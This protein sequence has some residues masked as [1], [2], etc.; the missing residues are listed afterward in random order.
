MKKE[1]MDL[2]DLTKEELVKKCKNQ[3]ENIK[4][5]NSVVKK[6]KEELELKNYILSNAKMSEKI[7]VCMNETISYMEEV[8]QLK[9]E[10]SKFK[11]I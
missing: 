8:E 7:R 5:L 9:Q 10:I 3:R 11:E 2:E 1:L 4:I 6:L